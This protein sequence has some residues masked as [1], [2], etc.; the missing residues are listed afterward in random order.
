MTTQTSI[1]IL[2][3][4]SGKYYVG[5]SNTVMERYQQHVSGEGSVWTRL[6]KPTGI[7]KIIEKAGPF[8]E[9]KFTKEMMAIHGID[10]VRGGIY[11]TEKISAAN[12]ST[13]QREIWA[14]Q[15]CCLICGKKGH[16]ANE[17]HG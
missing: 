7:L 11:T 5:K 16:F 14:A 4:E 6:Y 9:D 8:D 15:D 10:N 1:Y 17:C 13:L 2:T 3:L 12:C